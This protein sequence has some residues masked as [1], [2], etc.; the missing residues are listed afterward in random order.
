MRVEFK[1]MSESKRA[2]NGAA[3]DTDIDLIV[4]EHKF[5]KCHEELKVFQFAE[6][7]AMDIFELSKRFPREEMYSLTDQI[8]R[9]SRSVA[10]SIAEA[11]R[12]RRYPA[13]FINKLSE[14]ESEAGEVQV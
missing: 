2:Y 10:V 5:V 4:E 9:S 7:A 3:T 11:W 8:R 12:R 14:P 13:A 6:G 1:A